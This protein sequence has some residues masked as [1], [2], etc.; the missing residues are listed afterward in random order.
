ML[1]YLFPRLT[2]ETQRGAAAFNAA[3]DLAR[4]PDWYRNGGI[5][6]SIDGR[7][8]VLATVIALVLVRLEQCGDDG[9]TVSVALTERFIGVM[10]AEHRELGLGDPALGR[11]VRRLVGSLARRNALWRNAVDGRLAWDA[12]IADSLRFDPSHGNVSHCAAEMKAIWQ[13]VANM[14]AA[15]IEEGSLP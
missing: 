2:A 10:E 12:A 5:P 14:S 1:K 9:Q 6:D 11:T 3:S 4:R 8:A 15:D 13:A 7:F